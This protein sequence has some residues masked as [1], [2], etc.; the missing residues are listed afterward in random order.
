MP[1]AWS[2]PAFVRGAAST[3]VPDEAT[4]NVRS[5]GNAKALARTSVSVST[6]QLT[7][8]MASVPP[9]RVKVRGSAP[10]QKA[11]V[12][13]PV[14]EE[15]K[16]P[17]VMEKSPAMCTAVEPAPLP[18]CRSPPLM[19]RSPTMSSVQ[20]ESDASLIS[21][22]PVFVTVRSPLTR[23]RWP[24]QFQS[25]PGLVARSTVRLPQAM[26]VP[27]LG[28]VARRMTVPAAL[29]FFVTLGLKQVLSQSAV[30]LCT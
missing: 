21:W 30:L 6:C 3:S 12:W 17:A 24:S 2:V 14:P 27:G 26:S 10:P 16:A 8:A 4:V 5:A 22:P 20:L 15:P 11:T 1:F 9:D 7:L 29:K 28:S 19:T 23:V 13:M 18:S 25:A